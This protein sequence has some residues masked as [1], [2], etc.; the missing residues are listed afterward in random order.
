MNI[1]YPR[2]SMTT[3]PH[4]NRNKRR[5]KRRRSAV[6]GLAIVLVVMIFVSLSLLIVRSVDWEYIM[7]DKTR[8]PFSNEENIVY[9]PYLTERERDG[10][11]TQYVTVNADDVHRGVCILV[12]LDT[13]YVFQDDEDVYSVYKNK[14]ISYKVT[15]GSIYMR[16][17][18]I[19]ALNQMMDDFYAASENRNIMINSG[20]RSEKQQLE[21]YESK[22]QTKG[23]E[24]ADRYVQQPG[25]SEHH[26]GY[27]M[28]LAVYDEGDLSVEGDEAVWTFD[29][30]GEYF[31]IDKNC[32]D[33]GYIL[34]YSASKED[35]TMIA[36]ESWHYR[37]VGIG[38]ALAIK[39]MG[40]AL[41]EYINFIR[42]YT[43]NGTRYYVTAANGDIYC[44]YYVPSNGKDGQKLP[45]PKTARTY[46][47]SGNNIDGFIVTAVVGKEQE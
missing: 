4:Q 39:N 37:Y 11:L 1:R 45:I 21:V 44:V 22:L 2:Q 42:D 23:K 18:A 17:E 41:E 26:T 30:K 10:Y 14:T 12:N 16:M 3:H 9:G 35:V 40:L 33:Y 20:Y 31:W 46:Q 43:Y 28:D 29:G 32:A 24:Y 47:I 19:Q 5:M 38:N 7:S 13:P 34:R 27:A 6:S 15:S 25:Y 8:M 36:Y